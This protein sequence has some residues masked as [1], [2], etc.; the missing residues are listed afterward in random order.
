MIKTHL[1]ESGNYREVKIPFFSK[2]WTRIKVWKSEI[3]NRYSWKIKWK[4]YNF[5]IN[6]ESILD[7]FKILEIALIKKIQCEPWPNW[8]K[9]EQ[10]LKTTWDCRIDPESIL[11][12]INNDYVYKLCKILF[13]KLS[14]T[15][16]CQNELKDISF[17]YFNKWAYWIELS[18][19]KNVLEDNWESTFIEWD[20]IKHGKKIKISLRN[21]QTFTHKWK[22]MIR[23]FSNHSYSI[24]KCYISNKWEK[25]CWIVNP[26]HT[27]IKFDI[28][29]EDCKKIFKF[30]II[31][32]DCKNMFV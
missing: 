12:H 2:D 5:C 10:D 19:D 20:T 18:I 1:K 25:R 6:S 22:N 9:H 8:E 7:W 26:R 11:Y 31:W 23:F 14:V 15:A 24:Q 4:D 17:K 16:L 29:F 28:S 21:N 32:F 27:D 3:N 30:N 13:G